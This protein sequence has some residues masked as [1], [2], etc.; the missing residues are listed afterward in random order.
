MAP[1]LARRAAA[2]LFVLLVAPLPGD[3]HENRRV[4]EGR[5]LLAAGERIAFPADLHYHRLVGTVRVVPGSGAAGDT[6]VL[7][8]V[9]R[10]GSADTLT[11]AGPAHDLRV[12]R[13]VPCCLGV[14][15]SPHLVI[16]EN[17]GGGAVEVRLR[18]VLL[19]DG[20]AV[21]GA[22]SEPGAAISALG[23]F[24]GFA[25]LFGFLL[26]RGP[27]ASGSRGGALAWYLRSQG[28]LWLAAS[29]LAGWGMLRYGGGPAGGIIAVGADLPWIP[30]AILT[31][32]DLIFLL[33]MLLWLLSVAL[34]TGAARRGRSR[35]APERLRVGLAGV[36]LGAGSFLAATVWAAEYGLILVPALVGAAAAA[37]PLAGG[38]RLLRPH[39]ARG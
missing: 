4:H 11:L 2:A 3:A 30:N 19:H 16:V 24:G 26:L 25:A 18:L 38:I 34:W 5:I 1:F 9:V 7:L 31:T 36:V 32:Q 22:N 39:G 17:P 23:W 6:G 12:S 35:E 28:A 37:V 10:A 8:R 27:V 13:L 14:D 33:L 21:I 20:F 15:W 29:A